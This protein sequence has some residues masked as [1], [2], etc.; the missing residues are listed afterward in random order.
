MPTVA[1]AMAMLDGFGQNQLISTRS[2]TYEVW[3]QDNLL[4]SGG[5]IF[6]Q[7]KARFVI[8]NQ[9]K[10]SD[11]ST[12][13]V[14]ARLTQGADLE[15]S[16]SRDG[17]AWTFALQVH[18][19][20]VCPMARHIR[21]SA[22]IAYTIPPY[23][24]AEYLQKVGLIPTGNNHYIAREFNGEER[25]SR[26]VKA[27]DFWIEHPRTVSVEMDPAIEQGVLDDTNR[28]VLT[29]PS[30][31]VLA[32]GF[33]YFSGDFHTNAVILLNTDDYKAYVIGWPMVYRPELIDGKIKITKVALLEARD[34]DKLSTGTSF[35][36][37]D[38]K[39]L[40][41]LSLLFKA[42]RDNSPARLMTFVT[43]NC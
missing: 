33:T 20:A 38:F 41:D 30:N 17:K 22:P 6:G 35:G 1:V 4:F 5:L 37:A 28:T 12:D 2:R 15:L 18:G 16:T 21:R 8:G 27:A 23:S 19:F 32:R 10:F 43:K 11:V 40:F 24:D 39:S 31:A 36:P 7:G 13:K 25:L 34:E 9:K 3:A 29:V 26:L 42:M 14:E